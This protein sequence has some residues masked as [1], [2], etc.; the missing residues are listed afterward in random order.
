MLMR[1]LLRGHP[2]P[3][4]VGAPFQE[5]AGRGRASPPLEQCGLTHHLQAAGLDQAGYF[6][7]RL[8][9]EV[10][11]CSGGHL[12]PQD[13]THI[14]RHE[15]SARQLQHAADHPPN[16]V[17]GAEPLDILKAQG[18]IRG[19]ELNKEWVR[20]STVQCGELHFLSPPAFRPTGRRAAWLHRSGA[21]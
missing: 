13:L 2:R 9:P 21:D 8:E 7:A 10:T 20:G 12:S 5:A 15:K 17:S 14:H 19:P 18:N 4:E 11:H 3:L 6:R 1:S 16:M